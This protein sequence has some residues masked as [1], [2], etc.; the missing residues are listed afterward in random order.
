[1]TTEPDRE[2]LDL[3]RRLG[4]LRADLPDDGFAAELHRR[5]VAAG[6]PR[7]PG[8][9][10]RLRGWPRRGRLLWPAFGLATGVA[11]FLVL[12][13]LRG[14]LPPLAPRADAVAV[15]PATKV[16]VIRLDL[17][18]EVAVQQAE[19]QVRLPD[20]LVFWSDGQALAERSYRWT[21]ALAAGGN[22]IPIAVRGQRPG[23]Y[24]VVVSALAGGERI[25]HEVLLQVT[26]G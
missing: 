16:A 15:V 24:R 3:S 13:V 12:E 1:M 11:A 10:S 2:D 5:L 25:E 17:D 20:G 23:R 21:Q 8:L 18:V 22:H 9:L 26:D 19:I 14:S 4:A 6:A 7:P